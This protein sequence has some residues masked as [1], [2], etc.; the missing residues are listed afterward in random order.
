MSRW[1]S[2]PP[3]LWD[4]DIHW[5]HPGS[6]LI[7]AEG[8]S[9]GEYVRAHCDGRWQGV[10]AMQGKP[11]NAVKASRKRVTSNEQLLTLRD[12]IGAGWGEEFA[13]SKR[14]YERLILM[15]DPDADGIHSR[16]LT[17]LFLYAWMRPLLDAGVV[18]TARPPLWELRAKDLDDPIFAFT[19]HQAEQLRG[20]LAEDGHT[21]V[22]RER[23]RGLASM[24]EETLIH[25]CLSPDT[26]RLSPLE[27]RHAEAVLASYERMKPE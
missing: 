26:R 13:L 9:A 12:A 2:G 11:M 22:S 25:T 19:D 21:V 15:F 20:R 7:I 6:E 17:L 1:D 16:A 23:F 3:K 4:C 8:D 27:A 14:R 24:S 18:F 10:L 5:P